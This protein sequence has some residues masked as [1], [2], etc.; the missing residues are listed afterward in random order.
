[1]RREAVLFLSK[2]VYAVIIPI[3]ERPD[4]PVV[5]CSKCVENNDILSRNVNFLH[6]IFL[7]LE[8]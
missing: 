8:L 4:N 6:C 1:M 3:F 2:H 7:E 5:N